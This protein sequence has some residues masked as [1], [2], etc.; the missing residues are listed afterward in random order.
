MAVVQYVHDKCHIAHYN[1]NKCIKNID[2]FFGI[3][4]M[5]TERGGKT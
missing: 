1:S 3:V 5:N 2:F 4:M